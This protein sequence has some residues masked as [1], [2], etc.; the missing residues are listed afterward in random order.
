MPRSTP[1]T[2]GHDH[3]FTLRRRTDRLPWTVAAVAAIIALALGVILMRGAAHPAVAAGGSAAAVDRPLRVHYEPAMAGEERILEYVAAEIAP[4][5]GVT[6]EPVGIAD[7]VQAN[8]AVA[9]GEVDA[10]IFEHQWYMKQVADGNGFDLTPTTELYQWAFGLYSSRYDSLDGVPAGAVV[11]VPTDL[12]NQGQ[13]LW[14]L[15]REGLIE[16]DPSIEP[17]TARLKDVTANPRGFDFQEIDLLSMPRTLDSVDVAVGYTNLFDAG[18]VSRD[19]GILFPDPPRS[20]ASRL[21]VATDAVESPE[22]KKLQ[23]VFS[24]PKFKEYLE[25]TDDPLVAGV[26]TPV[27]ED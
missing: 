2:T 23:E 21:I 17:R 7:S 1:S 3:G 10:T 22:T 26:L 18:K 15:Q 14:L 6:I 20:F 25:T 9:T 27:S 12:A 8:R 5:H 24:D 16:L 19:K 13:A 4:Q 11:A